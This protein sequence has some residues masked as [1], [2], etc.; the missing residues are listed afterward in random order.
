[1]NS[2]HFDHLPDPLALY[3]THHLQERIINIE[4]HR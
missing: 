4:F 1:M 2:P 3:R